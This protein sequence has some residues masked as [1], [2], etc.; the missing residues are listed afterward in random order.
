MSDFEGAVNCSKLECSQL[1]HWKWYGLS[2]CVILKW[3]EITMRSDRWTKRE[4]E[5]EDLGWFVHESDQNDCFSVQ[6][7]KVVAFWQYGHVLLFLGQWFERHAGPRTVLT[8]FWDYCQ[9]SVFPLE[10][11]PYCYDWIEVFT[12]HS[13]VMIPVWVINAYWKVQS[14]TVNSLWVQCCCL[15]EGSP[16]SKHSAAAFLLANHTHL[17]RWAQSWPKVSSDMQEMKV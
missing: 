9:L 5:A 3:T 15:N 11:S 7:Q 17:Q 1:E 12:F 10:E 14:Q 2:C 8:E 16:T 4:A 13:D 6:S